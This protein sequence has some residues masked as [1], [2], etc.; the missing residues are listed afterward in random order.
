MKI[1]FFSSYF[2]PYISGITTYPFTL[3]KHLAEKHQITVLTFPHQKELKKIES[4]ERIKI[5][6]IPYLLKISKGYLSPQSFFYFLKEVKSADIVLLNLPNF[7]G[8][9]LAFFS[10]ILGKK[11]VCLFHCQVFL[12]DGLV[13]KMINFFLNLSMY[14][15]MALSDRIIGNTTD[16][17]N[18]ILAGRLFRNKIKVVLP[19]VAKLAAEQKKLSEFLALKNA[20]VWIGFSGRLAREKGIEYLVE[21]ANF[22][23][24]RKKLPAELVFAGPYGE[25]VAGEDKYF[26]KIKTLLKKKNVACRFFGTLTGKELGA[27]Y[28]S[29][30]VLVLP[31]INQSEAFGMVQVE[32]ML[33]G[34]P[35]VTTNLPGVQIPVKVTKMGLVVEKKNSKKLA[36]AIFEVIKN[37]KEYVNKKLIKKAQETFFI[38]NNFDFWDN[39]LRLEA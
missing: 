28:K 34:T 3:L 21:V 7:E 23:V 13:N 12:T 39:L 26:F 8:L 24:N 17:I 29:I 20:K 10:K 4:I 16:Y 31:S 30:D 11:T 9:P 2:Y 36:E 22:L 14:L 5:A 35:V 27:F 25:K 37:R 33:L 6:R 32:A 18:S 15:Q 1:L 38:K 19:P